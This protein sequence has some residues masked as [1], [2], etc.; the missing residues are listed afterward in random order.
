MR[1]HSNTVS[2]LGVQGRLG[3]VSNVPTGS[4]RFHSVWLYLCGIGCRQSGIIASIYIFFSTLFCHP[5]VAS[6]IKTST[7]RI[8]ARVLDERKCSESPAVA[9]LTANFARFF[10]LLC[11]KILVKFCFAHGKN[12]F[13]VFPNKLR[14]VQIVRFSV[15]PFIDSEAVAQSKLCSMLRHRFSWLSSSS[16]EELK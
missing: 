1:L 5:D 2:F 3:K 7:L 14:F 12:V 11:R 13:A 4:A 16:K 8:T 6:G 10:C 9:A 15:L